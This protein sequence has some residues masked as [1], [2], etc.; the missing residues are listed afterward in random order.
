MPNFEP[1]GDAV[2]REVA[3]RLEEIGRRAGWTG[4][5]LIRT[6]AADADDGVFRRPLPRKG[7]YFTDEQRATLDAV[8][9]C[10]FPDDGNGPCARDLNALPYL[11]WTMTDPVNVAD[12]DP[13]FLA[14]GVGWLDTLSHSI[15]GAPFA[16]Q[17]TRRR[18][19]LLGTLAQTKRGSN[20]LSLL[21]FYLTEALMLDPCYGGNPDMVG[22]LW[23]DHR[24]GFPRPVPG[25]TFRD[26]E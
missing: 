26:F 13:A 24:P 21:L 3:L 18:N 19:E 22:W 5:G 8:Q 20:W 10:L 2:D 17:P 4:P 16:A 15:G 12:G 1:T 7:N 14:Q 23:L 11:E 25:R 9:M 6:E